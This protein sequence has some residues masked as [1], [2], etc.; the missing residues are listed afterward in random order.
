MTLYKRIGILIVLLCCEAVSALGQCTLSVS[1]TSSNNAVICSGTSVVL[2]ATATNGTAP[3]TYTWSTGETTPLIS[4]NK[5]GTYS[6]SVSDNTPGCQA[7]SQNIAV[8]ASPVPD[9]PTVAGVTICKNSSVTLTATA[10]G[11]V[12]QWYDAPTGGNLLTTGNSY[13]TP[14]INSVTNYYVETTLGG[15]TSARATVTVNL[16]GNPTVTG[17]QVCAGSQATLSA[18]GGSSYTWYSTPGGQLLATGPTFTTPPLASTT[19]YYVV[20]VVNGCTGT[21][22]PVTATVTA[23]PQGPTAQGATICYGS[24]A[25]LQANASGVIDWYSVPTGGT[26]LITSP[27]FTTPNLTATTT[28]YVQNTSNDCVSAR[29]PVTVTVI[30]VPVAPSVQPVTVCPGTGA[31]L[32]ASS[33]SGSTFNWYAD[34]A[35]SVLLSTG[36]TYQTP[37]LASNTTYYVQTIDQGCTSSV[38]T[39]ITVTVSTPPPAPTVTVTPACPGSPATL[40]ATAP[41]GTYQWYD[42]PSGGN[43]LATGTSF[44]TPGLTANTVYYVQTTL[45][46]CIS[47]RA[48]VTATLYPPVTPPT[49]NNTTICAGSTTTLVASGN[50][51]YQWFDAATGGNLLMSGPAFT[52]PALT[53]TTTY[54]VQTTNKGCAVTIA[55]TPVTVTISP[56][57]GQPTVSPPQTTCPNSTASL[58]ASA[59]G[60]GTITWY[61]S[62]TGGNLLATGNNFTTPL[63]TVSTTYY[64]QNTLG[65][66]N[67]PRTAVTV[68]VIAVSTP[69]FDYSSGTFCNTG[70][71]ETPVINDQAGGIF[72]SAPAGLIF[73]SNSTGVINVSASATGTYI[74]TF[75]GNESCHITTQSTVSITSSP[76]GKFSYNGPFCQY[77]KANPSPVFVAGA[78]A[79]AFSATPAGLVFVNATSGQINLQKSVPGTYTVTNTI[80]A[81]GSCPQSTSTSTVTISAGA[82]VNAGPNQIVGAGT[83]VQLAGSITG[84][85]GGKWTGGTGSFSNPTLPNAVYTP[86]AGETTATLT[87][88]S[89]AP[90]G[91][92]GASSS[93]V[94]I[95]FVPV[96]TPP[97]ASG[98]TICSGSSVKLSATA[99]GG[100]YTWYDAATGGNLLATGADFTTPALTTNTTYY[101]E[102]TTLGGTSTRTTVPVVVT[103]LPAAPIVAPVSACAN[104]KVILK[105]Q[106]STGNYEWY[107][108]PTG[109]NL[110]ATGSTYTTPQLTATT[111]YY[112][113]ASGNG[114]ASPRTAV[115]VSVITVTFPQFQYTTGTFCLTDTNETPTVSDPAGGIF[116]A[117]PKGLVFASTSTGDIDVNA[118]AIG[119]YTVTFTGNE[120]CHTITQTTITIVAAP[121]PNFSYNGP[122]CQYGSP[123]PSPVFVPPASAGTFSA[124]PAG[125]VFVNTTSGQIDLQNSAPGTYTVT[126]TILATG[127]CPQ[128]TASSTVTI[129]PGVLVKAGPDQTVPIGSTVQLAGSIT[130]AASTGTW[131]GGKGTFSNPS[132]PNAVYTPG[133][134]ETSAALTLTSAPASANCGASSSTVTITFAPVPTAPVA[135]G[136]TICSGSTATLSAT[137]P[138]GNYSWYDAPTGGN[139]LATGPDFT[140]TALIA[141][142]TYYVQT[143]TLGGTSPMTAVVVTVTP[144]P[145]APVVAPVTACVNTS[146]TLTAQGSTGNYQWYDVAAGGTMLATGATFTTPV[147]TSNTTYYVQATGSGCASPR[148]TVTVPVVAV[149][150]PQFQ[151]SSGTFCSSDG[152]ETPVINDPAG[153]VFSATPAG[154]VF[155]SNTTGEIN[156][157]ASSLGKY[158]ITFAGN[159]S[160]Q[161]STQSILSIVTAPNAKFSYNGPFCQYNATNPLPVFAAGASAGS[162]STAPAGL[163]FINATTGQIDIQNSAPGTYTVTNTIQASGS[164]PQTTATTTVT[165]S[166]GVLVNAGPDQTVGAG[167]AVQLAGSINGASGG[168]WTGGQGT[169][170]NPALL[171]AVY[172]PGAGETTATLTLT[173]NPPPGNCGPGSSQVVITFVQPPTAPVAAEDTICSGNSV[174]LLATA[175]GGT[176]TWFDAPTAGNNLATGPTFTTPALTVTTTYYVQTTTIGGTSPRTAV[177]VTV[178]TVSAPVVSSISDCINTSA[179]L[180]AQGSTGSYEWFNAATGGT[181]LATGSTFT[182][183]ALTSSTTYY[184]QATGNGCTSARVPATVTIISTPVFTSAPATSIC[185]GNALN[186][187]ITT[188][189]PSATYSW[190]RSQVAGISNPAVTNAASDTIG[191]TLINTT[192]VPVTVNYT[193]TATVAGCNLVSSFQY[194]VTVL[195]SSAVTSPAAINVCDGSPLS[196]AITFSDSLTTFRWSRA[197]V[198]GISNAAVTGQAA[199]TI[200]EILYN[201][202]NSPVNVTYVIDYTLGTC[203]GTF[204]LVATVGPQVIITSPATS[205]ECYGAPVGYTINSNVP[206]ATFSWTRVPE[207]SISNPPAVN[208]TSS[209]INETLVD[210]SRASVTVQYIIT[211]SAYGCQFAPFT[212]D[213]TV[214]P[215]LIAPLAANTN[216]PICVGSTLQLQTPVVPNA[217]YLWT[218]PNGYTSNV[219]NPTIPNATQANAGTYSLSLLIGGCTGP[220]LTTNVTLNDTA[221]VNAG[222]N[223]TDCIN[224][225]AITLS[226][227]VTGGTTTGIW[228]TSGSGIFSPSVGTLNAQYIPSAQDKLNGSVVLT[229]ASTSSDNCSVVTSNTTITFAAT[230]AVSAGPDQIVCSESTGIPLSGQELKPGESVMWTTAGSG[231]F[232]PSDTVVNA[233]YVPSAADVKNGTVTLTLTDV[234]A[235]VCDIPSDTTVIKFIPPPTVYAGATK[236]LLAGQTATL[237]P[238]VNEDSVQYLWTPDVNI[239]NNTVKNPVI[240]GNTDITYT[241]TVTDPRGCTSQSQVMVVIAP[242][243]KIDNAF[244][245]NGDG[246]NDLW[247]ITGLIAYVNAEVDV[248]DRYGGMVYHSI[249]YSR[250]W[251]GTY[252][253]R[254]LPQGTYYYIIKLNYHDQVLSGSVTVIR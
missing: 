117:L 145:A 71:N 167:N 104:T 232:S 27:V 149:T 127:S 134:G 218:G 225:A 132:L 81:T 1:L 33:P 252:N 30:P 239:S 85:A 244:T 113:Q 254:P 212:L 158:T 138:G 171:N 221:I 206:G 180:T 205:T 201:T 28:Y 136:A 34:A 169:F 18:A 179:T 229:L 124:T 46:G 88:T 154:L 40:T 59:S 215:I 233:S 97:V 48:A 140:T 47:G 98:A 223:Q 3:Y 102:T 17:A 64:V 207:A 37:A 106:G 152:N 137:A 84:V 170:S 90:P 16:S 189:T 153:G 241:L 194:Q 6:V 146:I 60:G 139:L 210:T 148:T 43:L 66:C 53:V 235:G 192:Q 231:T 91:N 246:I 165:I 234:K 190:S 8:T 181:M 174:T 82:L 166:Q 32:T 172:T 36:A 93:Q 226:G 204:N 67:S 150:A 56:V 216:S 157:S 51:T 58:T 44:I 15:C 186:Y 173:S 29:T 243:I 107:D 178:N 31:L 21:A 208:Q 101:V 202:T 112:V 65:G 203:S 188:S 121:N 105:A 57:P 92:C 168:K 79:G 220:A 52:T 160:C 108:S 133:A 2:T 237:E 200:Q 151:Y 248:F 238:V 147:L 110:L 24:Y 11:G 219:Q 45:N 94:T 191:E 35:G 20:A 155:A 61:D 39:P 123:S 9:P 193:I 249:G 122:F 228:S 109:G 156:V 125:L 10:P 230:P 62:A 250:P 253:S 161:V 14:Q 222:P 83:K 164:C 103:P 63:L 182:T 131:T 80:P 12:Y 87:L 42:A 163:V 242:Q 209:T 41:G 38:L 19:T 217:G 95:T 245:P 214:Y 236:Y 68:P 89:S 141:T 118:S 195:P 7:V 162:F 196:Y 197:A 22:T 240:T 115:P 144:L 187:I 199:N 100:T 184:V 4:V 78:S 142:T 111:T 183:P 119:T 126:N 75:T 247:N 23:F 213:V 49:V 50:D 130:G 176:Y 69:Q 74:I 185:S 135:A 70:A 198:P 25:T 72:S 13:V 99:P 128:I 211:P 76:N 73:V 227:S 224:Q 175:P 55:R 86:G 120:S 251:D 26:S 143:T 116:S 77:S 96:P 114:C 177:V 129:N 159:E 54:Y 5:A